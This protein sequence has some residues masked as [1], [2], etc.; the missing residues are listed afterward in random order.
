[1]AT[2]VALVVVHARLVEVPAMMLVGV[3][4]KLPTVGGGKVT[5]TVTVRVAVPPRP[6]AVRV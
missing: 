3:A 4:V 6:V 5:W 2:L 1:M